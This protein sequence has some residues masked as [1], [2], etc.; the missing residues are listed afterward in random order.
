[1]DLRNA[2][3][4]RRKDRIDPDDRT[5]AR[6]TCADWIEQVIVEGDRWPMQYTAVADLSEKL[7]DDGGWS[8]QHVTAT[9]KTYFEPVNNDQV[10]LEDSGASV[11]TDVYREIYR[12]GYQDGYSDGFSDGRDSG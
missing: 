3:E 10:A 7:R 5:P 4:I 9:L 2:A 1:M 6:D 8:R 12:Q 11:P